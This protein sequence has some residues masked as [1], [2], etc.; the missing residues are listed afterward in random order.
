M[1]PVLEYHYCITGVGDNNRKCYSQ[2][3]PCA[4][5]LVLHVPHFHFHS[6]SQKPDPGGVKQYFI[7]GFSSPCR[8]LTCPTGMEDN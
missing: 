2:H 6:S 4:A 1:K 8:D 5:P 3:L 7:P